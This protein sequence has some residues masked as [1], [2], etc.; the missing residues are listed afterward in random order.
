MVKENISD[1]VLAARELP[2]LL[3]AAGQPLW[4][5]KPF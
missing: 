2:H 5:T 1:S 3:E 4:R